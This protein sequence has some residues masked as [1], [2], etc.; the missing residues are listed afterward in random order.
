MGLFLLLALYVYMFVY[1]ITW[2][3]IIYHHSDGHLL[4]N[5]RGQHLFKQLHSNYLSVIIVH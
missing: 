3:K 4:E 1:F 5:G 2:E